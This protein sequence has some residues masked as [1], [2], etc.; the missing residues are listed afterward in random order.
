[1]QTTL[2]CCT[3]T[4]VA[5]LKTLYRIASF[6]ETVGYENTFWGITTEKHKVGNSSIRRSLPRAIIL[7]CLGESGY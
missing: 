6:T 2:P 3:H 7:Q 4:N 5:G 1:M